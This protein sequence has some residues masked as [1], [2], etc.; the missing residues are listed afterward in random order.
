MYPLLI[1]GSLGTAVL[2]SL[3]LIPKEPF[4]FSGPILGLIAFLPTFILLSRWVGNKIAPLFE[5]AQRQVK[6]GKVEQA[7]QTFEKILAYKRW[8]LYLEAQVNTQIGSLYYA[9]GEDKKALEH[10]ERGYPRAAEGHLLLAALLYREKKAGEACEA[11]ERGIRFNKKS[12]IL[13]NV[14]AWM[15]DKEG[16]REEAIAVL[17]RGLKATK[18]NEETAA[19]LERL[20]AGKKMSMKGFGQLWYMLKFEKPSGMVQ[21]QPF[22]KGFRQPPKGKG[23]AR[24]RR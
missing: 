21:G 16:K 11:L 23:R 13:Y 24:K 8:Q 15:L 20:R 17:E 12:A 6:D 5:L 22:R 7:L 9:I 1:G 14:L 3:L 18:G 2:L 4:Y 19:N 10:L